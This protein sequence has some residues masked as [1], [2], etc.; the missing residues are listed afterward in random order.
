M[1]MTKGDVSDFVTATMKDY[2]YGRGYTYSG[3]HLNGEWMGS[4]KEAKKDAGEGDVIRVGVYKFVRDNWYGDHEEYRDEVTFK[5]ENDE[6]ILSGY[7][8]NRAYKSQVF[9]VNRAKLYEWER[10]FIPSGDKLTV[11]AAQELANR[12]TI[13][14]G[15][16]N[17]LPKVWINNR[18]QTHSQ[19]SRMN[20]EIELHPEWGTKS[21]VV[22]HEIAHHIIRLLDGYKRQP[23]HGERYASVVADIYEI[24]LPVIDLSYNDWRERGEHLGTMKDWRT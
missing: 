14:F 17:R 16:P 7:R 6:Y 5:I 24:Y 3:V 2:G 10:Q 11:Q 8:K 20:F 21:K 18:L 1:S 23:A 22:L 13:D 19:Y 9:D 4:L 12:I 15:F